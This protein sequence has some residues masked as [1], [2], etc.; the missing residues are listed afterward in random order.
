MAYQSDGRRSFFVE[1]GR[2]RTRKKQKDPVETKE[3]WVKSR[4]N[5]KKKREK[6]VHKLCI[7]SDA[8]T[9]SEI[10]REKDEQKRDK[11]ILP[12]IGKI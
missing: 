5:Q 11:I 9:A 1:K 10:M 4:K 6:H 3:K 2:C 7:K 8:K 12:K